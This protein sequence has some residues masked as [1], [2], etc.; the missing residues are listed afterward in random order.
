MRIYSALATVTA[1]TVAGICGYEAVT[2]D[3]PDIAAGRPQVGTSEYEFGLGADPDDSVIEFAAK[4]VGRV[5]TLQDPVFGLPD[6]QS[7]S[8]MLSFEMTFT[9][10]LTGMRFLNGF[11]GGN[12]TGRRP[13]DSGEQAPP[14]DKN[15][16]TWF[17]MQVAG[18]DLSDG[19]KA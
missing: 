4:K 1:F 18:D 3:R 12:T 6:E 2:Y 10:I 5:I 14:A 9:G 19:H 15:D 7:D 17:W 11:G 8:A 16:E 13:E